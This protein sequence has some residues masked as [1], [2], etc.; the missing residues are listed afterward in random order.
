MKPSKNQNFI[1][2]VKTLIEN[3]K[4]KVVRTLDNQCVILYWSIG[5]R[6]FE[7][8]Q[9]RQERAEYGKKLI[10]NLSE[11]IEPIYGIGEENVRGYF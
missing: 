2:D 6:I 7:E 4:E 11:E 5:K 8:K 10:R 3:A 9:E 1:N